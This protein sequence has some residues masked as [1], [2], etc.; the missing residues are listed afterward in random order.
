VSPKK[1]KEE[2]EEEEV[3][4]PFSAIYS[5]PVYTDVA[6]EDGSVSLDAHPASH[7]QQHMMVYCL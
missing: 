1:K 3:S 7:P 4:L 2:E 6:L 5:S